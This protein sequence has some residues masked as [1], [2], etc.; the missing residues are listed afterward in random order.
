MVR[1]RNHGTARNHPEQLRLPRAGVS[2]DVH[3]ALLRL[4]AK[5]DAIPEEERR[6][7]EARFEALERALDHGHH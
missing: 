5:M 4:K 2:S 7:R 1:T 6:A 3:S